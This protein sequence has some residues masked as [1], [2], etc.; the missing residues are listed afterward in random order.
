MIEQ[1][2]K[3]MMH[4]K[5][6]GKFS[7]VKFPCFLPLAL[8]WITFLAKQSK[9]SWSARK[10]VWALLSIQK[11]YGRAG[12]MAKQITA[13]AVKAWQPVLF[14]RREYIPESFPDFHTALWHK[15]TKTC[16]LI[17]F[18]HF[19]DC[20]EVPLSSHHNWVFGYVIKPNLAS[21]SWGSD[22][23]AAQSPNPVITWLTFACWPGPILKVPPW[24]TLV[25]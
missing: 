11:F 5:R 13:L 8:G 19:P 20:I 7:K 25:T 3:E 24:V 21:L 10:H 14:P 16:A 15:H 9:A 22:Y 6:T 4:R 1:S 17:K 18:V 23:Y 2:P 12:K